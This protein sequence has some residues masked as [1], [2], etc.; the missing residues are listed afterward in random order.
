[1]SYITWKKSKVLF[2]ESQLFF[3]VSESLKM[4]FHS[5]FLHPFWSQAMCDW[6]FFQEVIDQEHQYFFEM[7]NISLLEDP[8]K[9]SILDIIFEI[10]VEGVHPAYELK[11]GGRQRKLVDQTVDHFV[12]EADFKQV[13]K[14]YSQ[15]VREYIPILFLKSFLVDFRCNLGFPNVEFL[16]KILSFNFFQTFWSF[17]GQN[18]RLLSFRIELPLRR[19]DV[20]VSWIIPKL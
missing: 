19:Y 1:V 20:E 15:D 10:Y 16:M 5:L 8:M 13:F 6:I 17:K 18:D 2:I 14:E 12:V 9:L 3:Y 4:H 7:G 11:L